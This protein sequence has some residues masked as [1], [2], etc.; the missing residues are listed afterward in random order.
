[1]PQSR[2]VLEGRTLHVSTDAAGDKSIRLFDMQGHMLYSEQFSGSTATLDLGKV[3]RG[4]YMVRLMAG[5]RTIAV[6]TL[7]LKNN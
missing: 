6:K 5:N 3:K 1:M 2:M 7:A 4:A